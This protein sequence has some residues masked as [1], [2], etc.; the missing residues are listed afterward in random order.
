MNILGYQIAGAK[1]DEDWSPTK[2]KRTRNALT[3]T[4]KNLKDATKYKYKIRAANQICWG[5]WSEAAT[6]ETGEFPA[7]S[8][9]PR[10]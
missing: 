10:T 7:V 8:P 9:P 2:M 4:Q 3:F 1:F 6:F 5:E